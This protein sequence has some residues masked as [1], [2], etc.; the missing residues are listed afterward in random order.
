MSPLVKELTEAV[1]DL[2]CAEQALGSVE[3]SYGWN[4]ACAKVDAAEQRYL[5]AIKA[6]NARIS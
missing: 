2:R 1:A 6:I 3:G 5:K 4:E